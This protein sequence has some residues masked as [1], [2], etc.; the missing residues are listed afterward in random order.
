MEFVI[1]VDVIDQPHSHLPQFSSAMSMA[2]ANSHFLVNSTLSSCISYLDAYLD[3][4]V[5]D[6]M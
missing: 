2:L 6:M 5:E 3:G 1:P 4:Y